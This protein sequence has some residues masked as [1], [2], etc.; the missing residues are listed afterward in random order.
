MTDPGD[1]VDQLASLKADNARLRRLLDEAGMP[2]N[3]R[4][5]L[6]D[7]VAMLRAMLRQSAESAED[8]ESYAAH[9]DGRLVALTRVR[10]ATDAFGEADLH[11][12]IADELHVH[13]V[14]DGERAVLSGPRVRLRPK[15]AQVFAMA[16]HELASNGV[17]HGLLSRT[18]GRVEVT[19]RTELGEAGP[20]LVL[21]WK[22]TGGAELSEPSRRGYGTMV[23]EEMLAYQLKA[24]AVLAYEPDGLRCT[25]HIP[26]AERTGRLVEARDDEAPE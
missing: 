9:L 23:L 8:A 7:T 20:L 1:L 22:E 12:L 18:E 21:V 19:W 15:P 5:A 16:M 6:R 24:R 2:D 4:H 11:T 10:A 13:L 17:E 25:L 26:F 14:R 3:L